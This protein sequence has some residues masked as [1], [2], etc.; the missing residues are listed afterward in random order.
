MGQITMSILRVN[1][2][3]ENLFS[4]ES[5]RETLGLTPELRGQVFPK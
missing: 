4:K 2:H 3:F 1:L 5:L